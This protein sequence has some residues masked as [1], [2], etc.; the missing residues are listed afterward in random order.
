PLRRSARLRAGAGE[1]CWRT[2]RR[3]ADS[4]PRAPGD[5]PRRAHRLAVPAHR[6]AVG[7]AALGRRERRAP[8]LHAADHDH[9]SADRARAGGARARNGSA[10]GGCADG[11]ARGA[12][13]SAAPAEPAAARAFERGVAR[14]CRG[15][16]PPAWREARRIVTLES[17]ALEQVRAGQLL[18]L[19]TGRAAVRFVPA[20]AGRVAEGL[21]VRGIPTSRAT[22]ELARV[23][24]IPLA[25][26][27]DAARIDLAVDGADEVDPEGR[28]IK[29]YGGA[30][31]REKIVA[32]FAD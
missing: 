13:R 1:D 5:G 27:E 26:L 10:Q 14:R 6:C 22:E 18:G 20:L 4:R 28:L 17:H 2:G 21:D 12:A 15:G 8:A 25:S 9:V 31:L 29:G 32:A 23:L 16:K 3:S 7:D 19:G 30:L 11:G 24:G